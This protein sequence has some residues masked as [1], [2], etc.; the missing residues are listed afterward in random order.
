MAGHWAILLA[1]RGQFDAAAR[2]AEEAAALTPAAFDPP[3]RAEFLMAQAE[4][5]RL[6]GM[7]EEAAACM[8]QA[9]VLQEPADGPA[10]RAGPRPARQPHRTTPHTEGGNR[11]GR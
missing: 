5:S 3:E 11:A 4:V 1:R 2:L 7:L 8:R 9:A 6:A 10:G